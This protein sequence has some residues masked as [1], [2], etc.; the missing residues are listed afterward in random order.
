MG[1]AVLRHL[2]WGWPEA[3][4]DIFSAL[5]ADLCNVKEIVIA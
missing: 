2:L 1:I 3:C 4:S 5:F